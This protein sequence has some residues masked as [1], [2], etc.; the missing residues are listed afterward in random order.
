MA[1]QYDLFARFNFKGQPGTGQ[2]GRASRA[3]RTLKRNAHAARASIQR[4]GGGLRQLTFVAA[5]AAMAV[6][7]IVKKT[8]DFNKQMSVVKSVTQATGKNYARLRSRALQMGAA[9]SFT[10]KEA[11]EGMEALGRAS[12]TTGEIISAIQPT[13]NMAAAD[14]MDLG[15]AAKI[16]ASSMKQFQLQADKANMITDVLAYTSAKS[17]TNVSELGEALKYAGATAFGAGQSFENTVGSLAMLANIGIKGSMAGTTLKNALVKLTRQGSAARKLF[18]GKK[19]LND[20]L[21]DTHGKMRPINQIILVA[22]GRLRK[23]KNEATRTKLAFEIFGIRG[24]AAMDAFMAAD[25]ASLAKHF[26]DIGN[27]A[28]GMASKM[29]KARL[30]NLAGD[31]TLLKSAAEG[32]AIS[33]GS[34]I[35]PSLRQLIS[36]GTGKGGAIAFFQ[37]LAGAITMVNTGAKQSAVAKKYGGTIAQIAF[38]IKEAI[39]GVK[40]A[41]VEVGKTIKPIFKKFFGGGK[42]TIKI[43]AKI[44]T[45]ALLFLTVLAPI[46]IGLGAVSMAAGG[47]FKMISGGLGIL[48]V[49]FSPLGL[50]IGIVAIAIKTLKREGESTFGFMHRM[51]KGI[52]TA[53]GPIISALKWMVKHVGVLGTVVGAGLA[54]KGGRMLLGGLLSRRGGAAGGGVMGKLG[55]AVSGAQQVF[56]VNWPLGGL[57]G[58]GGAGAGAAGAAARGGAA[59][60]GVAAAAIVGKLAAPLMLLTTGVAIGHDLVQMARGE[61]KATRGWSTMASLLPEKIKRAIERREEGPSFEAIMSKI[62]V[63]ATKKIAV[64]ARMAKKKDVIQAPVMIGRTISEFAATGGEARPET[65]KAFAAQV[66]PFLKRQ[67]ETAKWTPKGAARE[68]V[69]TGIKGQT[70]ARFLKNLTEEQKKAYKFT[71]EMLASLKRLGE[72][73]DEAA[74]RPIAV[75]V[76][77]DGKKIATAVAKVTHTSSERGGKVP[78]PGA[79]RRALRTGKG[80]R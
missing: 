79:K 27:K 36:A 71:P 57:G 58:V 69:E 76:N 51:V 40:E 78:K 74:K 10:A 62:M 67:V 19:G 73:M 54:V 56:V 61:F 37:G 32:V 59:T 14:T 55:A 28:T 18:G 5:G 77:I 21:T 66:V 23:I 7:L 49:A 26:E 68:M 60:R 15:S 38:G 53:F 25:P 1:T 35:V 29:A 44:V 9:T 20:A 47:V 30:D 64:E 24:K 42:N 72:K 39:A 17:N 48:K 4:I 2:V 31:L 8:M 46:A 45:K 70:L 6:G 12:L 80:N 43:I 11:G 63:S 34:M 65:M 50:T 52:A 41:F 75:A 3:F 33:I 16:V 22:V 13:L